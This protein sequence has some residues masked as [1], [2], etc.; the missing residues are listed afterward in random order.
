MG[1]SSSGNISIDPVSFDP[2]QRGIPTLRGTLEDWIPLPNTDAQPTT[3]SYIND[4]W[5]FYPRRIPH[6]GTVS[7][8]ENVETAYPPHFVNST[9]TLYSPGLRNSGNISRGSPVSI[10]LAGNNQALNS[11]LASPVTQILNFI[12]GPNQIWQQERS[13]T[14]RLYQT[15][16]IGLSPST[17]FR[18]GN[19]EIGSPVGLNRSRYIT[20]I[21]VPVV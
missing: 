7:Q 19:P 13:R 4:L 9:G 17:S 18:A 5:P 12:T 15:Q 20:S 11:S 6:A 8:F 16:T 21:S 10:E 2:S 14:H 1:T 3:Y